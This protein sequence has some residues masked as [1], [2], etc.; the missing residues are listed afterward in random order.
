MI[1]N[2]NIN[3]KR[4]DSEERV[5]IGWVANTVREPANQYAYLKIQHLCIY[6]NKVVYNFQP[7]YS[8]YLDL[9]ISCF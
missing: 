5:L 8:F 3:K 2:L 1:G 4:F 9:I 6:I 7:E